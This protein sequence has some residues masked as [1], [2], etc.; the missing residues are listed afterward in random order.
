MLLGLCVVVACGSRKEKAPASGDPTV[1]ATVPVAVAGDAPAPVPA[2]PAGIDAALVAE[3][4]ALGRTHA[5]RLE[6]AAPR[7]V[8]F[9]PQPADP[10]GCCGADIASP[11]ITA[12]GAC[13]RPTDDEQRALTA[14][15]D[16]FVARKVPRRRPVADQ[17]TRIRWG[18]VDPGGVVVDVYTTGQEGKEAVE[19]AWTLRVAPAAV[20]SVAELVA[21]RGDNCTGDPG[22]MWPQLTVL[23][24]QLDADRDRDPVIVREAKDHTELDVSY[25]VLVGVRAPATLA[26]NFHSSLEVAEW[27]P[28]ADDHVAVIRY[29]PALSPEPVLGC[30]GASGPV[31]TCP[32]I[33]RERSRQAQLEGAAAL[34]ESE[35]GYL[36]DRDRLGDLLALLEV[37]AAERDRYLAAAQAP[38]LKAMLVR[39][40]GQR[41][42]AMRA[43]GEGPEPLYRPA[44]AAAKA[45]EIRAAN[46]QPAC[47]AQPASQKKAREAELG[48]FLARTAD[49]VHDVVVSVA[50]GGPSESL[51]MATWVDLGPTAELAHAALFRV[52]GKTFTPIV[53][54]SSVLMHTHDGPEID[55][56]D[57]LPTAELWQ[58]ATS[59]GALVRGPGGKLTAVVDGKI[60]GTSELAHE[61]GWKTGTPAGAIDL[62]DDGVSRTVAGGTTTYWYA[63]AGGVEKLAEH[64]AIDL[65]GDL[66]ATTPGGRLLEAC[67]RAEAADALLA[68][69]LT[70]AEQPTAAARAALIGAL[71]ALGASATTVEQARAAR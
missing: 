6:A 65:A 62:G 46:G 61:L 38:S 27:Q 3:L 24:A 53:Q 30:V 35:T 23:L 39:F 50:C 54:G 8:E 32:S 56:P 36:V 70:A 45:T 14:Q 51:V 33:E 42:A 47:P 41:E 55:E 16:A 26:G 66:V 13:V 22:G 17:P 44:A 10:T 7:L 29:S 19:R 48:R 12:V 71:T 63:T 5:A 64:G 25:D 2:L 59:V 43:R 57:Q 37:P 68:G 58:T 31:A 49:Q 20:T 52:Q 28:A 69:P 9:P 1:P 18:C 60:T 15:V 4:R 67:D 21:C 11:D 34:A 40:N